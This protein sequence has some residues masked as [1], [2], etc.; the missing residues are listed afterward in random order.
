ME[1]KDIY[2]G[3]VS[4]IRPS[5]YEPDT[6]PL[7]HPDKVVLFVL[8][9]IHHEEVELYSIPKC[10]EWGSNPRSLRYQVLSLAP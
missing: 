10:I 2:R 4:I 8:T 5:G 7:R 6:L 9:R 1:E 3:N